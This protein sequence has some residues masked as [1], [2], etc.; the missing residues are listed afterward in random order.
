MV[1]G[2]DLPKV[3]HYYTEG[4]PYRGMEVAVIGG[5]NSAAEAALAYW[6]AGAR[7]TLIHR[8]AAISE[9]VKYWVRPDVEKRL[10]LGQIKAMFNTVVTR[11]TRAQVET[12]NLV[13]GAR[14]TIA[15]DFVFALTGYHP[16]PSLLLG[17][18]A[19]IDPLTLA[20]VHDPATLETPVKGLYVAGSII[21]GINNNKVFIENSREHGKMIMAAAAG[22]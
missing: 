16:D 12:Q 20:P 22:G 15:N 4:H 2:E 14:E 8:G 18:G 7:V 19:R 17:A 10:E 1:E 9:G 13:T 3:S 5:K 21:A 6:R 11:I